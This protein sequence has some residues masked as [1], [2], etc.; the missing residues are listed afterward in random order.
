MNTQELTPAERVVLAIQKVVG[1]DGMGEIL[2]ELDSCP[3]PKND[4]EVYAEIVCAENERA[5][6]KGTLK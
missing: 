1:V 3:D 2:K 6:E 4:P 5:M